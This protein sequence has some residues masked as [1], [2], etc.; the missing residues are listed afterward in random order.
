MEDVMDDRVEGRFITGENQEQFLKNIER[1]TDHI[2]RLKTAD[3]VFRVGDFV[4]IRGSLFSVEEIT[5]TGMR[6][7]LLPPART[8]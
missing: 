2:E 1:L 7:R 6:L 8:P 5:E 3:G 4:T